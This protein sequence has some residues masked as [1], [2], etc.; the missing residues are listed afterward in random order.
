MGADDEFTSPQALNVDAL[1]V[2][3]PPGW[4]EKPSLRI[5]HS[6]SYVVIPL[7]EGHLKPLRTSEVSPATLLRVPGLKTVIDHLELHEVLTAYGLGLRKGEEKLNQIVNASKIFQHKNPELSTKRGTVVLMISNLNESEWARF[8]ELSPSTKV[9]A[10]NH[11]HLETELIDLKF[12]EVL[13]IK[14]GSQPQDIWDAL[15][16]QST[17]PPTVSGNSGVN[18]LSARGIPFVHT[19]GPV[20]SDFQGLLAPLFSQTAHWLETGDEASLAHFFAD[21]RTPDSAV[22][23]IFARQESLLEGRGDKLMS[24]LQESMGWICNEVV[25]DQAPTENG[26]KKP[27]QFYF[28][29]KKILKQLVPTV[30]GL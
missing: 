8:H 27:L 13:V 15:M 21:A 14:V 19:T 10:L 24:V 6:S 30:L 9:L 4:E 25:Q 1:L 22:A 2:M 17:L 18:F 28:G 5:Q 26:D 7:P 23:K 29:L 16:L 20:H 11:E 12:G 3:Q